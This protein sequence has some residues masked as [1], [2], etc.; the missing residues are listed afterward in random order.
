MPR[1]KTAQI[2]FPIAEPPT[3][4]YTQHASLS[5][6]L[7]PSAVPCLQALLTC[8][9]QGSLLC[10]LGGS[11]KPCCRCR[12]FWRRPKPGP[13]EAK[14][15]VRLLRVRFL[16]WLRSLPGCGMESGITSVDMLHDRLSEIREK[17][18]VSESSHHRSISTFECKAAVDNG[19]VSLQ[20]R[21]RMGCK[22]AYSPIMQHTI[23]AYW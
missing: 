21:G 7:L 18:A 19:A 14:M 17:I 9:D 8:C 12:Y 11:P 13:R 20:W 5:N 15:R 4:S 22:R 16:F 6:F 10:D 1:H 2:D 3:A 23:V